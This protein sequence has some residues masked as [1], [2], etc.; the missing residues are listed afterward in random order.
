[1]FYRQR[2]W[3]W[4]TF[5]YSSSPSFWFA[6]FPDA[7]L[8]CTKCLRWKMPFIAAKCISLRY[9]FSASLTW[10]MYSWPLMALPISSSTAGST[11]TSRPTFSRRWAEGRVVPKPSGSLC[12]QA[13]LATTLDP[14]EDLTQTEWLSRSPIQTSMSNFLDLA[15]IPQGEVIKSNIFKIMLIDLTTLDWIC[16][17]WICSARYVGWPCLRIL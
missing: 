6:T 7:S 12:P 2:I 3:N 17:H 8:T 1:M 16:R 4:H 9:G 15:P 10:P 13:G 5:L 14:R 11:P